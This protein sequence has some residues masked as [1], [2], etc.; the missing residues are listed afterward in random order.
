M[1]QKK[2]IVVEGNIGAGKTTLVH[3]L[4]KDLGGTS[5]LE[6]FAENPFLPSFYEQNGKNAFPL[7]MSFLIARHKQLMDIF[8][9]HTNELIIADFHFHKSYLFASLTLSGDELKLYRRF[10]DQFQSHIPEH[11]LLIFLERSTGKLL[12]NIAE[13]GR[14]YE[15]GISKEYLENI[16]VSYDKFIRESDK[17]K[18]M[19]ITISDQNSGMNNTDYNLIVSAIKDKL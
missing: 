10:F 7:E 13:R 18:L 17:N 5:V 1:K 15:S 4:A 6:E 11:D 2:Y 14:V 16:G 9:N 12:Q 19:K 3:Q 8:D